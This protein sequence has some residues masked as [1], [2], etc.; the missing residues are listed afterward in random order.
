MEDEKGNLWIG[1]YGK[2]L[3]EFNIEKKTFTHFKNISQLSTAVIYGILEDNA[4]NL[5]LSTN[6]G[7]IKFNPER[8][9]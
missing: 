2:G 7:I 6:N 3:D 8:R 4:Q 1:T 5:W 9:K